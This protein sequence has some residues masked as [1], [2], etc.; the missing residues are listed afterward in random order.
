MIQWKK[1]QDELVDLFTKASAAVAGLPEHLQVKAFEMAVTMMSG[2][3]PIA[4]PRGA[5]EPLAN[6]AL[7]RPPAREPVPV[8][9][10]PDVVD[11]LKV[12]KRNPDRYVVFMQ[13]LENKGEPVTSASL[14]QAFKRFKQDI[15]KLPSRDL[16]ELV[17]KN[18][19]DRDKST[20]PHVFT[21]KK[22]GRDR[23]LELAVSSTG[24]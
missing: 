6:A 20:Y 8:A 2:A 9:D 18:W 14:M 15:P 4:A 12:C 11:L 7:S 22:K 3:A 24:A 17:A 23:L 16:D 21:L 13:E 19:V 5:L 1:K 10:E